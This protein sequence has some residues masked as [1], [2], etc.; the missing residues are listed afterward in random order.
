LKGHQGAVHTIAFSP[1][2]RV[3]ASGGNDPLDH[4]WDVNSGESLAEFDGH[5]DVQTVTFSPDGKLLAVLDSHGAGGIVKLWDV[6]AK[7]VQ[8]KSPAEDVRAV[9]FHP[10]EP[11]Q[12]V[13]TVA[14][15][16]NV[17]LWDLSM[18]STPVAVLHG[19]SESSETIS[20]LVFSP[21]GEHLA[22]RYDGTTLVVWSTSSKT[23]S[24]IVAASE[25]NPFAFSADSS[26]L[27]LAEEFS[28]IRFYDVD[29]GKYQPGGDIQNGGWGRLTSLACSPD[30]RILAV[31]YGFGKP[32]VVKVV[33]LFNLE[34]E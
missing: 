3:L 7:A 21:N 22:A 6:S 14:S 19:I 10:K 29:G 12:A 8:V 4:L 30:G 2:G 16:P 9:T 18:P 24:L 27:A 13:S 11:L 33:R 25:G 5:K 17:E 1:N 34:G 32:E 20:H 15:A 23:L 28:T 26:T 31:G